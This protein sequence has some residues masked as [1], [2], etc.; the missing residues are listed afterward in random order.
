LL[1][2]KEDKIVSKGILRKD[3]DILISIYF[4]V[5]DICIRQC[6]NNICLSTFFIYTVISKEKT[7][8]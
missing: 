2:S 6:I 7:E 3:D 5:K 8:L 1:V 4:M